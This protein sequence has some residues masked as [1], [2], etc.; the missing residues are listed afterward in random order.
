M[1]SDRE[2]VVV[3]GKVFFHCI[4][5]SSLTNIFRSLNL[6]KTGIIYILAFTWTDLLK[7]KT[8]VLYNT[9][10]KNDK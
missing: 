1:A 3:S 5:L 6:L 7:M 10:L 2:A 9:E 4:D 8:E